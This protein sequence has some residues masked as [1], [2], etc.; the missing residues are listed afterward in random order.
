MSNEGDGSTEGAFCPFASLHAPEVLQQKDNLPNR[1][2]KISSLAGRH[3]YIEI[4][5]WSSERG[6]RVSFGYRFG[7]VFALAGDVDHF[8]KSF[9]P[10]RA[11]R[12]Q[13]LCSP[14]GLAGGQSG[15]CRIRT[16]RA[17]DVL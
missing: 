17:L 12:R 7:I 3:F 14:G 8:G 2:I 13:T 9:S 15:E 16:L 6:L 4:G 10:E 11:G 5:P 1:I